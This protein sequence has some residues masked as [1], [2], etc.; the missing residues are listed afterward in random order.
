LPAGRAEREPAHLI[1]EAIDEIQKADA[2]YQKAMQDL[3]HA[4]AAEKPRW[5]TEVARAFET[6]LATIDAAVAKQH[7]AYALHPQDL[8]ALDALQASY[9]KRIEFLQE[10]VVRGG[11]APAQETL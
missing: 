10:A 2:E 5:R 8:A 4:V 6:N 11:A 3:E 9:Q 7:E 1:D